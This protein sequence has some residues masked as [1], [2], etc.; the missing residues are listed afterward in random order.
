MNNDVQLRTMTEPELCEAYNNP[1]A[2][3]LTRS[4]R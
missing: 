3:A 1:R 2:L 4:S